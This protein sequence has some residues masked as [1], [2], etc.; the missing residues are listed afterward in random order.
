MFLKVNNLP[1][2]SLKYNDIALKIN[3]DEVQI[4]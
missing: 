2:I 4:Y 1:N 3:P